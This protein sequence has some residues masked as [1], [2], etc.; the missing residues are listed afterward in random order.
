MNYVLLIG[1][2]TKE[3]EL[4]E[5]SQ[6]VPYCR[7]SIAVNRHYTDSDGNKPVDYINVLTW[8]GLADNCGKYLAKGRKVAVCGQLQV[9]Q[10]EDSDGNKRQRTEVVADEVEF[11]SP[12][13]QEGTREDRPTLKEVDKLPNDKEVAEQEE[14]PF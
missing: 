9:H 12:L 11:L 5:T 2:L 10:Y 6:G 13:S 7:F 4:S 8:R 14:L 3:P 1:N